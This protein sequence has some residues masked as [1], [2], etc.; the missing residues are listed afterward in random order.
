MAEVLIASAIVT[1]IGVVVFSILSSGLNLF[2]KNF[3]INHS[4]SE[5]RMAMAKIRMHLAK[6]KNVPTLI[7]GDSFT[8]VASGVDF[9][10][11]VI[12]QEVNVPDNVVGDDRTQMLMAPTP[13]LR[14]AAF[15]VSDGKNLHYYPNINNP[16]DF[17]VICRSLHV[18]P[19][20]ATADA[21][22]YPFRFISSPHL[23]AT[24][25]ADANP[26]N[27]SMY[28]STLLLDVQLPI[29]SGRYNQVLASKDGGGSFTPPNS[30]EARS[31][32]TFVQTRS[33]VGYR[34]PINAGN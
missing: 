21:K 33:L 9:G 28:E 15:R 29:L 23:N 31:F 3:S 6:A 13:P 5:V 26:M 25:L 32:S 30:T 4:Q 18:P 27:N 10:L 19:P 1:M 7:D 22:Y 11:G 12:F 14:T 24:A 34:G 8:P 2:A 17:Q 20:G 16:N